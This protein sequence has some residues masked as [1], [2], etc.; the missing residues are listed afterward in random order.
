MIKPCAVLFDRD[1]TLVVDVPFN[2]DPEKVQP[3]PNA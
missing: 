2:G 3:V 1:E